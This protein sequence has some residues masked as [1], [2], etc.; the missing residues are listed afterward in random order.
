[1]D[2][3]TQSTLIIIGAI[4]GQVLVVIAAVF[5]G[6]QARDAKRIALET[7]IETT[8]QTI[9]LDTVVTD[10]AVVKGHVNS[11]KTAGEGRELALLKE[12][13]LLREMIAEKKADAALLAQA[14]AMRIRNHSS[15]MDMV[16]SSVITPVPVEIVNQ[17]L[18]TQ[19]EEKK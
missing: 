12:N 14:A 9:K 8:A 5:A 4:G 11:E 7:K 3:A 15:D 18:M 17:P 1:M 2:S 13:I 10:T 19:V 6:I 16:T